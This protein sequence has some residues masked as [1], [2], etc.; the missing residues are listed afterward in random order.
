MLS[1]ASDYFRTRILR[2][3]SDRWSQ[4]GAD[5]KPVLVEECEEGELEAAVAVLR[6]MYEAH[7]PPL[8]A[9]Q[10]AQVRE[11]CAA[12]TSELLLRL[13]PVLAD[14]PRG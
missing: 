14:V 7:V 6:L 10:L 13:V 12:Y 1:N 3:E 9:L 11:A 4:R 2:W 5:G 8:S